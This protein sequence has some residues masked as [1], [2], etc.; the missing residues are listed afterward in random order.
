[1]IRI[2]FKRKNERSILWELEGET[3]FLEEILPAAKRQKIDGPDV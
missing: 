3:N 1:M 2:Y